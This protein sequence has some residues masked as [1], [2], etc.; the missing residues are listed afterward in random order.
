M[1]KAALIRSNK[2][3][4]EEGK[5]LGSE[6]SKTLRSGFRC[7]RRK[8]LNKGSITFDRYFACTAV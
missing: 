8:E 7:E 6:E 3:C 4:L 2:G 5:D 1:F